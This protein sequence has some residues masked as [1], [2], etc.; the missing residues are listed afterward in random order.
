QRGGEPDPASKAA[1]PSTSQAEL[2]QLCAAHPE[3]RPMIA[4]HPNAYPQ[5]LEWL[6]RLGDPE[7]D[8]ALARRD[9]HGQTRPLTDE[10][11]ETSGAAHEQTQEFGAV[12]QPPSAPERAAPSEPSDFDHHVYGTPAPG[13]PS[14]QDYTQ[15]PVYAH[16]PHPGYPPPGYV[17]TPAD[18]A[19]PE[20][21]PRRRR[22]GGGCV[23][24]LI[25]ADRKSTR[26]NS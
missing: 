14:T 9:E 22:G 4:E 5:L 3:L 7:V 12:Q 6:G 26:L 20:A 19:E 16:Q 24:V 13:A 21:E 11:A 10:S 23:I 15:P 18:F 25:L 2:H 17:Y 1:D 8:A